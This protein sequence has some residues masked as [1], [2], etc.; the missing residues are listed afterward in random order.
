MFVC[1]LKTFLTQR[2][3][4]ICVSLYRLSKIASKINR[5]LTN[6]EYQNCKKDTI[7]FDVTDCISK[8]VD[9]LVTLQGESRKVGS[10]I[11]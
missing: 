5:Y 1:E 9:W 11:V 2:A 10:K 3:V 8:D 4:L 7:A 6:D